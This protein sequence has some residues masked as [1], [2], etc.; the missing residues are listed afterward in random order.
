[1]RCPQPGRKEFRF[2]AKFR[3]VS[4]SSTQFSGAVD[5]YG[6]ASAGRWPDKV[7]SDADLKR[8]LEE[9]ERRMQT[10]T[11]RGDWD[12]YGGL[13]SAPWHEKATGFFRV[14]QRDGKWW[15]ISP[16]GNPLFYTGLCVAPALIWAQTPTRGR[17][18]IWQEL[19]PKS[20]ITAELWSDSPWGDG[21]PD[22]FSPHAWNLIRKFG[23]DWRQRAVESC[24]R[25]LDAWAF[26][27]LGKFCDDDVPGRPRV[28]TPKLGSIAPLVRHIDVFDPAARACVRDYLAGVFQGK[29]HESRVVGV[30]VGNEFDEIFTT[31]EVREV[32]KSHPESAAAKAIHAAMTI[33]DQPTGEQIEQARQFYAE[34]YYAFLHATVK[35]LMPNHLYFGFWITPGWWQNEADWDMIVRH[36]DVVGYDKYALKYGGDDGLVLRLIAKHDKP[37]I[38]GEF[39]FPAWYGGERGFCRYTTFVETDRDSGEGYASYMRAAAA[40][41]RCIGA[42]WFQYRDEPITGWGG[43]GHPTNL[44]IGESF[45][46]GLVDITDRPKWD[47]VARVRE[48]NLRLT[49]DRL[50]H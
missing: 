17:E 35:E 31:D 4:I 11:R 9:E 49:P 40:D 41:P 46:E 6:Q 38:V 23:P 42:M 27:G 48:T 25:R 16:E 24:A 13:Q 28:E 39:S 10:W 44:V 1:V 50:G 18:H 29:A 36:C 37:T 34:A 2:E 8:S 43:P 26:S 30:S 47:V 14:T 22:Y 45:A 7:T 21:V 20:G 32:L 15:M 3:I 33:S 5:R 19:P 12:A